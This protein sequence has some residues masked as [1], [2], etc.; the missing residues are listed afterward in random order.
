MT[1]ETIRYLLNYLP[2]K[3]LINTIVSTYEGIFPDDTERELAYH[4]LALWIQAREVYL[5]KKSADGFS[6]PF[7]SEVLALIGEWHTEFH[8]SNTK[9]VRDEE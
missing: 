2:K 1:S 4:E 6:E 8:S 5:E 7:K 9:K 3:T